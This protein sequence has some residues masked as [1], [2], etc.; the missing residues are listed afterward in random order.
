M[1]GITYSKPNLLRF[2]DPG[3]CACVCVYVC[4]CV[5]RSVMSNSV[6]PWTTASQAILSMEFSRQKYWSGLPFSSPGDPDPGIKP[7]SPALQV[8]SLWSEPPGKPN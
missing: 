5:S 7:R 4:V 3:I 1:R 8:D 6:T 2:D